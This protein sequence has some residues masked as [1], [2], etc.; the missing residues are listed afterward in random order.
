MDLAFKITNK[1]QNSLKLGGREMI[2]SCGLVYAFK[3]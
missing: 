2:E 3:D 1:K